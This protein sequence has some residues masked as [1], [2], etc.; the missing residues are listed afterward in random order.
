MGTDLLYVSLGQDEETIVVLT[1]CLRDRHAHPNQIWGSQ[2][3]KPSISLPSRHGIDLKLHPSRRLTGPVVATTC[4]HL[5]RDR[6][7]G[8]VGHVELLLFGGVGDAIRID[9]TRDPGD[10]FEARRVDDDNLVRSRG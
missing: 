7:A 1:V 5:D 4:L 10:L 8:L 3:S 2:L 9:A 6:P